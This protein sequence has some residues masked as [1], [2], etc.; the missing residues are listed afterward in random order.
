MEWFYMISHPFMTLAQPGDPPRV[1][2]VQQYDT[3]FESDV[4]QQPMAAAAPDEPDVDVHHPGHVVDG[5]VAI[6]DK[7][8]RLLNLRILTEG[9]EAYIVAEECMSIARSYIGQPTRSHKSR[10][11]Q[12][13]DDHATPDDI[14][15]LLQATMT[16]THDVLLYYNERW[17]MPCQGDFVGYSFMEKNP[18][19]FDIPSGCSIDGHK[20]VIKQVAPQGIPP[21]EHQLE[22]QHSPRLNS[23]I[24]F[25]APIL[26]ESSPNQDR[27]HEI[28]V[29]K[30]GLARALGGGIGRGMGW[31]EH[32]VDVP[33]RR[34]PTAYAQDVPHVDEDIPIADVDAADVAADGAE[35]SPVEHGDGCPGGLCDTS[36]LTL[37]ADHVT[38]SIWHGEERPELKL[39][40][41]G[42]KVDKFGS[43]APEIEGLVS[44]IGLSPLIGCS[45]VTG[46]PRLIISPF[47]EKWHREI[48]TFHLPVGE[49]TITLDDVACFLHLPI[50]GALPRFEPLGVDEAILLLM[51]LLEVFRDLG[52]SGGYAWGVAALVHMY[53]QLNEASQTPHTTDGWCW[54]YE[55]FPSVHQCVTDNAYAETTPR[56]SRWLTTKAHM[57]GIK[58]APYRARLDA[59]TITDVSWFPY[60]EHRPVRGFE[61]ISCYQGQL[62]WGHV[63]VYIQPERVVR[64]FGYIQT[65]PPP[66]ITSSLSYDEID[67]SW[68]HFGDHLAP[69]GEICVVPGQAA[70]DYM[71]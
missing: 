6:V 34:R 56:A 21:N 26:D 58:G 13:V 62:R 30:R 41:H 4:P 7:L 11:R 50:I 28:K 16:H 18:K 60:S 47:A 53:D 65:I 44:G 2:S 5:Y 59:L 12:R 49:L 70:A 15:N 48:S 69:V 45:M 46:D 3:F 52:Q 29:R 1:L 57:K 37:F 42:R 40:S 54:I 10:R 25:Q 9:I 24:K 38:Y 55:Y 39:V 51:E 20:D 14:L 8:E 23:L 36:L 32:D 67:E 68:M 19:I 61:L 33:R 71:E 35:G 43:P 64:Q 31:D 17:N 22:L 63:V 66:P 27:H